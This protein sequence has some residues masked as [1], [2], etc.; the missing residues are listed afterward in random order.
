MV[1]RQDY[2]VDIRPAWCV[3]CGNFAILN[4]LKRALPEAGLAPEDVMLVTG[5]GQAAKTPD[6]MR[7][8]GYN[9]LHGRPLP[10]A[11]G[12]K[13][14][15]HALKVIV[16]HGDGDGYGEGGNHFM[17]TVR[18]NIGLIDIVH[19][20]QVY[21]LTKGQFSPTSRF[22]LKTPTSPEGSLER[23]MNALALALSQGATFVARTYSFNIQHMGKM[24][25]AALA[26]RGYALIEIM[27]VCV[28]F[29]RTM[30]NDFY[31]E[32]VYDIQEDGHD[33][34]DRDAAMARAYEFPGGDRIPVGIFYQDESVPAY[35]EMVPSLKET[36]LVS[37]PLH[38]RPLKEHRALLDEL[39]TESIN[40]EAGRGG[41]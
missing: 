15:N 25:A 13:L 9:G 36:P 1:T 11:T 27:Q 3:G 30:D 8:N 41:G 29:N 14:A 10:V 21:A 23:P 28:T 6:Y 7:I 5:I 2:D 24:L 34:G 26:H 35:E 18:R 37:Q 40:L 31:R 22:G 12:I 17:H 39:M 33:T 16:G 20:N 38:V 32:H 19:N 4:M